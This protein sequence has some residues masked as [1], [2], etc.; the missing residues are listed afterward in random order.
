MAHQKATLT[1]DEISITLS[2]Y[3]E[4]IDSQRSGISKA[5]ITFPNGTSYT[6]K[7]RFQESQKLLTKLSSFLRDRNPQRNSLYNSIESVINKA[8][9]DRDRDIQITADEIIILFKQELSNSV[10]H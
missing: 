8:E 10:D 5:K 2:L 9:S 1:L 6:E 3:S 4:K 7:N